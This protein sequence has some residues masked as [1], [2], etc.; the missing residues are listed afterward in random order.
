MASLVLYIE[1]I[2]GRMNNPILETMK[3]KVESLWIAIQDAQCAQ[4]K[5]ALRVEYRKAYQ[6]YQL[7]SLIVQGK[8]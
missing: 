5:A 1:G 6:S 2:G 3:S 7:Q 4:I 8:A